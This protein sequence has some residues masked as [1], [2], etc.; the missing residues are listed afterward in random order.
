MP[1]RRRQLQD[2]KSH[3]SDV[4]RDAEH[5]E[6][7]VVTRRGEEAAVIV[8]LAEYARLVGPRRTLLQVLRSAPPM[9]EL[10]LER[11]DDRG[12]EVDLDSM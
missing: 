9:D 12:R 4:I 1:I 5:G 8:G 7:T 11:S 3:L 2:V 6:T 10:P